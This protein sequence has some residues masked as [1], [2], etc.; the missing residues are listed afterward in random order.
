MSKP[1]NDELGDADVSG[2]VDALREVGQRRA[3][4]L[5]EI[6]ELLKQG[7]DQEALALMRVYLNVAPPKSKRRYARPKSK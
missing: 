7:K 5:R 1:I 3:S 4:S 6:K 2:V